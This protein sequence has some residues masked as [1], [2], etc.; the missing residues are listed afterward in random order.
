MAVT[1]GQKSEGSNGT[2]VNALLR[3]Y[4]ESYAGRQE[5]TV[6]MRRFLERAAATDARSSGPW[7]REEL[8]ERQGVHRY[9]RHL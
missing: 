6:A 7:T 4:L 8:H 3:Q 9:Q 1:A 2:S 5:R